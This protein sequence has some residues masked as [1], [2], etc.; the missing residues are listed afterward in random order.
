MFG[1]LAPI[2]LFSICLNLPVSAR[3]PKPVPKIAENK[4]RFEQLEL[5][6]KVLHLVETQYY[7]EVSTEKLIEG[8]L[9]GMMETLDPHSAFLNKDF[10]EKMQNDTQGEFGGLGLEV[11]QKEGVIYIVTP[12]DDTPA[13][14]AGVKP[15][16]RVV[17]INHEPIVGMT[18]EQAIEKMKGKVGEKIHMGVI[19]EGAEGIKHFNMVREMI[20]VKPVKHELLEDRF[21]YIRLTQFQ[22]RSTESLESALKEMKD[23]ASKSG[24]LTGIILDLRSNPGGLLDQAV[25]ISSMFLKEGVVVSTEARDPQNKD[26]RYVKKSG[27][28]DLT[29]PLVVLVNGASAS[30]SEIVAG[31]LQDYQRAVIM[32]STSFGKGSVQTVAQLDKHTGVKLTIAQYMTPKNRKI[33]AQ[34]IVPDV[35]LEEIDQKAFEK[36]LREDRYIREKDLKNHLTSTIETPAEKQEREMN[37]R[38]ERNRRMAEMEKRK[39]SKGKPVPE[40]DVFKVYS[41][42]EDFQVLQAVRYLKGF[43][44]FENF[45]KTSR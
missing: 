10:F 26:I 13:F 22:K 7:R 33:Q 45:I 21:A 18:L 5:F 37:E 32:G 14:R 36:D 23:K 17:E 4:S 35:M 27:Y 43:N 28:K 24:G 41:P 42:R 20:K 12:I 39:N 15:R 19:R 40:D 9:K 1:R 6:N 8:A 16:D 3:N 38:A 30:A 25:D 11:T 31:A 29:T 34:G 44:V 2:F